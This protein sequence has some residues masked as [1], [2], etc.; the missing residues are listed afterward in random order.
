MRTRR[1][2]MLAVVVTACAVAP[3]Q[4]ATLPS[5]TAPR[6]ARQGLALTAHVDP[7]GAASCSLV[8]RRGHRSTARRVPGGAAYDVVLR[9]GRRAAR[10]RWAL[11]VR[12][13][14]TLSLWAHVRVTGSHRAAGR[15]LYG[16]LTVQRAAAPAPGA[17]PLPLPQPDE[18][19]FIP[20]AGETQ[21]TWPDGGE[22]G[23][24]DYDN[25]RIADIALGQ[26]G[27][28]RTTSGAVDHGQCKQSVNDWVAEASGGR[29]RLSGYFRGYVQQGGTTVARDDAAKGDIIQLYNQNDDTKYFYGMHTAVVVSHTPGSNTFDVVDANWNADGVV[30]HH[31]WD[32]Y[33]TAAKH[34]KL[35]LAIWRMGTVAAGQPA[36]PATT[37]P[38]PQPPTPP[39][40][41]IFHV[42]NTCR[43]NACGLVVEV[44]GPGSRFGGTIVATIPDGT[45]VD[46]QC[47]TVGGAVSGGEGTNDVWDRIPWGN[48]VAFI[49]DLYVD[50]PGDVHPQANRYFTSSIPRC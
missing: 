36:P 3:A 22:L 27:L 25:A 50:T 32:P 6:S 18:Q 20:P 21:E 44:G 5:I 17:T 9:I 45:A 14:R 39:A 47:Q 23:G 35:D 49:P 46:I 28:D 15:A 16:K 1:L 40:Q 41:H 11:A 7:A 38:V 10:T 43:D 48:G 29:Q 24:G 8:T 4:A 26:L 19:G 12:C 34:N 30:R 2:A 13:D 31:T 33:A 37:P 42:H